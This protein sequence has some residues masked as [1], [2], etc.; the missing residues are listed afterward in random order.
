MSA[1]TPVVSAG[2]W[3][4]KQRRRSGVLIESQSV[5]SL[6]SGFSL[7]YDGGVKWCTHAADRHCRSGLD[8]PSLCANS[9]N[10]DDSSRSPPICDP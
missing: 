2:A 5:K 8:A 6:Q 4:L 7:G 9:S 1:S 10:N 3:G